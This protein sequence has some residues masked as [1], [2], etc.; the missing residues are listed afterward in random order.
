M[1]RFKD[2][3]GDEWEIGF[4]LP[5]I[6]KVRAAG[7]DLNKIGRDAKELDILDDPEK[8]GAVLWELCEEQAEKRGLTPEQFAKRFDGPAIWAAR[9]AVIEAIA[10][11]SQR[12][13]VAAAIRK[14]LPGALAKIEQAVIAKW[15]ADIEKTTTGLSNS[16]VTNSPDS[17][18]STPAG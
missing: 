1:A 17:P 14:R 4:D 7:F 18:E 11:F 5:T 13:T 16:G 3:T 10:D 12:P 9:D 6:P 2:R 15:E 8:L